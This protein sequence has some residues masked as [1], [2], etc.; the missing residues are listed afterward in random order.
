MTFVADLIARG[1]TDFD[2][3]AGPIEEFFQSARAR[4]A[5]RL[6]I[7]GLA[8]GA[9]QDAN[10]AALQKE[11][12]TL[13]LFP[14]AASP[15][16]NENTIRRFGLAIGQQRAPN[17]HAYIALLACHML[18]SVPNLRDRA[19]VD[20]GLQVIDFVHIIKRYLE[21][22]N[23]L[24]LNVERSSPVDLRG[25]YGGVRRALGTD[26]SDTRAISRAF[27]LRTNEREDLTFKDQS[28]YACYRYSVSG[29]QIVKSFLAINSPAQS[30]NDTFTFVHV[31][32]SKSIHGDVIKR[33]SRGAL[34]GFEDT[35]CFFGAS[36][37][38][39]HGTMDK[40]KGLKIIALPTG[41]FV[42]EQRL[43]GGVFFS[44]SLRWQPI[45]GRIALVHI[46]FRSTRD[47]GLSDNDMPFD[48]LNSDEDLLKDLK[49]T[50]SERTQ[51]ELDDTVQFIRHQINNKP[52]IA[53]TPQASE[54]FC[55]L[56]PE[57]SE[58]DLA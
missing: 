10:W 1:R 47:A 5:L 53:S 46:G 4:G 56:A 12:E 8:G 19:S 22:G 54:V 23:I 50:L 52:S 44:T 27:F 11:L 41:S 29:P 21:S 40:A 28:F 57:A 17:L 15:Q 2:Q 58:R 42:Y 3:R 18:T 55:S 25:I 6:V 14:K 31:H 49:S 16:F 38:S 32:M 30:D 33:M 20:E 39:I 24:E 45:V 9:R 37:R 48:A 34:I 13:F 7:I 43:L 26:K 36:A 51:F 35:F